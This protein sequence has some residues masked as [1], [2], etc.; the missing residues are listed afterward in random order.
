MM[1]SDSGPYRRPVPPPAALRLDLNEA[2]SPP[3]DRF[4]QAL[5][6]RLGQCQWNRYPD[7]D[8]GPARAAASK[9]YGWSQQGVLVG[10]GSNAL[11]AAA[12]RALLPAGGRMAVL[13]PSFSMYP[14]LAGRVGGRVLRVPLAPP[15]FEP[16][17]GALLR[18]VSDADVTVL[19]SPNNPTGGVVD[20][21]LFEEVLETGR[22]VV[23]DAAYVEFA[24]LT[25]DPLPWLDRRA[26]LL[27]LRSLSKVWGLAGLRVGA[28]L[29]RGSLLERV[30]RELLPFE[31]GWAV[32]AAFETAASFR[33]DGAALVA[34]VCADRERLRRSLAAD[35]EIEVAPSSA[36]FL[37]LRRRGWS[38]AGLVAA[39]AGRGIAVR[40]VAE[41]SEPGWVRVTVGDPAH[42]EV[43][44]AALAEVGRE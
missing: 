23:W 32:T 17:H 19:C 1:T 7:M 35:Q 15:R 37:L 6:D 10:N 21:A 41:L 20:E 8:A 11:L 38:G 43:V 30:G 36:N 39:L 31:T 18:A 29:G 5:M 24:G 22:P 16:D 25:G 26:N 13:S 4:R 34:T 12:V 40:E 28:L 44:A 2:P 3:G 33:E 9:L 27:V 14:V 42:N